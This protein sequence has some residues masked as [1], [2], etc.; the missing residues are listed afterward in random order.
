LPPVSRPGFSALFVPPALAEAISDEAWVRAMLDFEAALAEAEASIGLIPADAARRIAECCSAE[1]FDVSAIAA[2]ARAVGNPAEPLARALRRAVG[3]EAASWVHHGATSQDVLDTAAMLVARRALEIVE[4][5]LAALAAACASLAEQHRATLMV[6]RTLLQPAVPITFGLKAAGWLVEVE[7]ARAGLRRLHGDV[8][9]VELGGAAGTLAPLGDAGVAAL[10]ELARRLELAEPA[11]P[12]H[13]GRTRVAELA[14]A[15][16]V[17]AGAVGKIAQDVVLLAQSEVGEAAEPGG[18]V[19]GRSSTLPHKRNP[20]GSALARACARRAQGHVAVLLAAMEQEH[21]R[22]AGAWHAEWEALSGALAYAGGAA[23]A[24]REVLA[25]LEVDP[26]R[27]RENLAATRGLALAE[28]V[29]FLLAERA[30]REEA[31]ALVGAAG[32]RAASGAGLREELLADAAVREH[33]SPE[34]IERALDPAGYL[35][36]TD[37]FI[38]RALDAHRG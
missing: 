5:D 13:A 34:E 35:G 9:A 14:G 30:G 3:G 24:M 22:A 11:V 10:G 38:D 1:G 26:E 33:L 23:A 28:R 27:M 21:E 4:G 37:A 32:R 20:I 31:H 17:A 15:L 6:G 25:G 12:W 2:E 29:S 8:L 16:G 7:R 19:R 18:G 36:A